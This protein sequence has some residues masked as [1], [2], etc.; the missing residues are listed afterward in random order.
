[1]K[2][3]YH[4]AIRDCWEA[5]RDAPAYCPEGFQRE[6]FIHCSNAEQVIRVANGLFRG[7]RD[8]VL[9]EIAPER[10]PAEIR[11][12][13]LEGGAERF[14]HVYGPLN[15]EAVAGVWEFQPG[16]DGLFVMPEGSVVR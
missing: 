1:M 6:G 13:N 9:L 8:L 4:I 16:P 7:R 11:W 2:R 12:E 3:I 5:Q 14:P 10:V 15:K